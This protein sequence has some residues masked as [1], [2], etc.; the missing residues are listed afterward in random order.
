[1]DAEH[2]NYPRLIRSDQSFKVKAVLRRLPNLN[3]D[4]RHGFIR[5]RHSAWYIIKSSNATAQI[6][7]HERRRFSSRARFRT[8]TGAPADDDSPKTQASQGV[9][10]P[11]DA[12]EVLVTRVRKEVWSPPN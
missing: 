12:Q 4:C 9:G 7:N 6:S 10:P 2:L 1:M 3:L 8:G 5:G 11:L